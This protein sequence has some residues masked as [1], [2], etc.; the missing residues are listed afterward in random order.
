MNITA[1]ISVRNR[2]HSGQSLRPLSLPVSVSDISNSSSI[3]CVIQ[4]A[5]WPLESCGR[6]SPSS[7]LQFR[8]QYETMDLSEAHGK[9][10]IYQLRQTQTYIHA[11]NRIQTR[12]P[13]V[14]AVQYSSPTVIVVTALRTVNAFK[15]VCNV[16]CIY[17][18]V[19]PA[20]CSTFCW[21]Q[22]YTDTVVHCLFHFYIRGKIY[23][24]VAL[25]VSS[26]SFLDL[27]YVK[28]VL[29]C[30]VCFPVFLWRFH[31]EWYQS[32]L[33]RIMTS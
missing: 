2:N 10:S 5:Q 14:R 29:P 33:E 21:R 32:D 20:E 28:T 17:T 31:V 7:I 13:N 15:R 30:K 16:R 12:D 8:I 11:L 4:V 6:L 9:V 27:V 25:F 26:K 3:N 1:P 23:H 22:K 19:G 18:T 24:G